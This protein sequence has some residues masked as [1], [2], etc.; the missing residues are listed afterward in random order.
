VLRILGGG[1]RSDLW[2]QVHADILNRRIE[3]VADPMF[4]NLRGAGLYAGVALGL[5]RLEAVP[6]LVRVDGVFEPQM[7]LRELYERRQREYG[8]LYGRLS[9]MYA[10]LNG[11]P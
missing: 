9:G 3:R 11:R 1:A 8:K 2:C 6:A 10:A 4:A 5:V 7:A